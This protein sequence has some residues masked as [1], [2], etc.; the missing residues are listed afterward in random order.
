MEVT[1]YFKS[2]KRARE[3]LEQLK[4]N[5][6]ENAIYDMNDHYIEDRNVR[7]NLP[8]AGDTTS[9][10]GLIL[11][12]GYSDN[13][14]DKRTLAAANPMVSGMAGGEE[15]LDINCK[16]IVN[17]KDEKKA[18]EIIENMGGI[19]ENPYVETPKGLEN[20][21]LDEINIDNMEF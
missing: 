19:L 2:I 9:L 13:H 14:M 21:D 11:N 5:G 8:G 20:I 16:V 18:K 1:G 6:F 17:T 3:T 12:S 15:I 7:T 4:E 10:S